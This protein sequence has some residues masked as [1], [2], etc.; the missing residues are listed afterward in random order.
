MEDGGCK[1]YDVWLDDWFLVEFLAPYAL[2][3]TPE[4]QDAGYKRLEMVRL[5]VKSLRKSA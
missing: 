4:M 5:G 3:L 2:R 1:M